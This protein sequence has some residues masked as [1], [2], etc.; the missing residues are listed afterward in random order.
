MRV[1]LMTWNMHIGIGMDG[2]LDL[3]RIA[4]EISAE[5]PDLV[6]LQEVDAYRPRT[7]CAAQWREL[8]RAT[9][10]A[11]CYGP[12]VTLPQ[13]AQ[14]DGDRMP[15]RWVQ[16]YGNAVLTRLPV[17]A[18][19]LHLLTYRSEGEGYKEQRGCL[20]VETPDFICL[21]THWGLDQ[22][23]RMGQSADLLRLAARAEASGKPVVILGDL[24]AVSVAPE[25]APL[26]ERMTDAGAGAGPTF[27][28]DRPVRRI[29]YCFLPRSWRVAA[30]RVVPSEASDHRALVVDVESGA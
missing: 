10:M 1:R 13:D 22:Q 30:A 4:A 28:A 26:R 7:A 8:A 17:A 29:D 18:A 2:R 3:E 5:R 15:A 25:I 19:E 27:P 16:Q 9:G 21:A 20:E 24:N 12:N 6:A 11:A 14:P 23:E